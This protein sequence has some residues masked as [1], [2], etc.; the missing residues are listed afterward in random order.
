MLFRAIFPVVFALAFLCSISEAVFASDFV[1]SAT[2]LSELQEFFRIHEECKAAQAELEEV[3]RRSYE[4]DPLLKKADEQVVLLHERILQLEM[5]RK[6]LGVNLAEE[7]NKKAYSRLMLLWGCHAIGEA[8]NNPE[9]EKCAKRYYTNTEQ[10]M[11]QSVESTVVS[12]KDFAASDFQDPE[13]FW[14]KYKASYLAKMPTIILEA[15]KEEERSGFPVAFLHNIRDLAAVQIRYQFYGRYANYAAP[16][17]LRAARENLT[18]SEKRRNRA[19]Y[20]K[21]RRSLAEY[22]RSLDQQ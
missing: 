2:E 7:P 18:D 9:L 17:E 10:S 12:E 13:A 5:A 6:G 1:F 3:E 22:L 21:T 16:Q 20:N 19:W 14:P 4:K 15:Q 8:L 11:R